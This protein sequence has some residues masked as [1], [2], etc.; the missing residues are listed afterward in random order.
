MEEKLKQIRISLGKTQK[1]MSAYLG[2]GEVTWQNYERGISK[3]KLKTLQKLAD[4]GFNINW[5]TSNDDNMLKE[6][7]FNIKTNVEENQFIAS[8]S[9]LSINKSKI[10]NMILNEMRLLYE[11]VDLSNKEQNYLE[12]RAFDMTINILSMA[13]NDND[14][15]RMIKLLLNQEK[16][17]IHR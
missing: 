1:E 2:L 6:N 13:R 10:F 14:A 17:N 15:V 12:N 16:E 4:M 11:N 7:E 8:T 9:S 3:P 5:I